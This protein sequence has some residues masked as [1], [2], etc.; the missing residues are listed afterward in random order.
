MKDFH[1]KGSSREVYFND[2]KTVFK[3]NWN[4]SSLGNQTSIENSVYMS[5]RDKFGDCF[6]KIYRMGEHWTVQERAKLIRELTILKPYLSAEAY[7]MGTLKDLDYRLQRFCKGV[8]TSA[9]DL[10]VYWSK[11]NFNDAMEYVDQ[12][13][14]KGLYDL[15]IHELLNVKSFKRIV[16]CAYTNAILK[17]FR[18]GNLGIIRGN[19]VIVDYGIADNDYSI[20]IPERPRHEGIGRY[21]FTPTRKV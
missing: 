10:S 15:A 5:A 18:L 13:I 6:P 20:E 12:K 8:V 11:K 14:G 3:F 1:G 2:G 17:D 4:I 19:F 16:Q 7:A 21:S 9:I